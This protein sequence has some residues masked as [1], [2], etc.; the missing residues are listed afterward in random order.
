MKGKRGI[1]EQGEAQAAAFLAEQGL[2]VL[3]QNFYVVGG[4]IDLV[5]QQGDELVFVE[6]KLRN[7]DA[8]GSAV[9]S[10]TPKK[11]ARVQLAAQ[12]WLAA[13]DKEAQSWRIDLIAI[14][15]GQIEWLQHL[16]S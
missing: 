6:V 16:G 14:Q 10:V 2:S 4:E 1:G 13:H 7:S 8:F 9:E 11:L 12:T 3:E 15:N 5:C